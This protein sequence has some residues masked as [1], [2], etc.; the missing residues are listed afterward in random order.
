MG[1]IH[2]YPKCGYWKVA[3]KHPLDP[4]V[5]FVHPCSTDVL[6]FGKKKLKLKFFKKNYKHANGIYT[7]LTI[8][9]TLPNYCNVCLHR[10]QKNVHFILM[11]DP[12]FSPFILNPYR[13]SLSSKM[14]IV[15]RHELE[16]IT[17]R[18]YGWIS[19]V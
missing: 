4:T 8:K 19:R 2:F 11:E 1:I 3:W 9:V 13:E 6:G 15:M 12:S 10:M 18:F 16:F 7:L 14:L 5:I 17:S